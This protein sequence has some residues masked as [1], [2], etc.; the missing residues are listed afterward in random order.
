MTTASTQN[1]KFL[2]TGAIVAAV[3]VAAYGVGRIYPPL[4]P[5]EGTISAADRHVDSQIGAGDVGLG[6]T[7]V[8]QLMQTDAFEVMTKD[9]NFRALARD[10]NFQA[11]ARNPQAM[12]AMA[13]NPQAFAALA[14][15]PQAFA[16]M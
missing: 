14:R 8:A 15:D 10:A 13:A 6:D 7:S 1:R 16:Q 2:A 9:A 11:L 12:A 3:A 5:S 4:G